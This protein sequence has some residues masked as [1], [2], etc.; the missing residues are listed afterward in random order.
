M[1]PPATATADEQSAI[2]LE[3]VESCLRTDK[4]AEKSRSVDPSEGELPFWS[5]Q[6]PDDRARP[7]R[8]RGRT[9][10]LGKVCRQREGC[11]LSKIS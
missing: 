10:E 9:P 2:R 1:R 11:E 8:L 5:D 7:E 3:Q 4:E 6:T